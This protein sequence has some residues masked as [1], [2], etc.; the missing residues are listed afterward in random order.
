VNILNIIALVPTLINYNFIILCF[1]DFSLKT[2]CC[3]N[4]EINFS[5]LCDELEVEPLC[6]DEMLENNNEEFQKYVSKILF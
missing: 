1:S 6:E 4:L 5:K 3:S 2:Q